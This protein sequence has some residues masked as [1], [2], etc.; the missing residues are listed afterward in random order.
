M[1]E[2]KFEKVIVEL[3]SIFSRNDPNYKEVVQEY[4]KA[5][6]RLVQILEIEHNMDGRPLEYEAIFERKVE[7]DK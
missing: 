2:Y 5:G 1:Y 3:T 6:W 4:A 7:N